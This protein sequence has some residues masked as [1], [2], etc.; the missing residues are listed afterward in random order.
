MGCYLQCIFSDA[1]RV[2]K[3]LILPITLH[4]NHDDVIK[5]NTF[6]VTGHLCGESP[7]TGEFP[8]QRAATRSFDVFFDLRLNKRL[9]EQSWG[10]W[11]ETP[12][13][14]LWRHCNVRCNNDHLRGECARESGGWSIIKMLSYQHRNSHYE[15]LHK[16]LTLFVRL[17]LWVDQDPCDYST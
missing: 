9:N 8:A 1:T 7:V 5:G 15:D 2:V 3:P 10:S 14:P 11:S 17:H 12:S 16:G 13:C 4:E 6:R